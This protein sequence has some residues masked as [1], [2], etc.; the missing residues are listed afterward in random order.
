[1]YIIHVTI[2]NQHR[3]YIVP[4]PL[5]PPPLPENGHLAVFHPKKWL[6]SS[7]SSKKGHLADN[8]LFPPWK[9]GYIVGFYPFKAKYIVDYPLFS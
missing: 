8:E 5:A 1:M 3:S 6:F 4:F 2:I 9:A 7:F